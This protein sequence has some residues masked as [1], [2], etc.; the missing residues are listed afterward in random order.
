M[1]PVQGTRDFLQQTYPHLSLRS[2]SRIVA[3]STFSLNFTALFLESCTPQSAEE[4]FLFD[5]A[6]KQNF[7]RKET[8][9]VLAEKYAI[10]ELLIYPQDK[11]F[12]IGYQDDLLASEEE[13]RWSPPPPVPPPVVLQRSSLSPVFLDWRTKKIPVRFTLEPELFSLEELQG[14]LKTLL[15]SSE[16]SKQKEALNQMMLTSLDPSCKVEILMRLL[17]EELQH[18]VLTTLLKH[19]STLGLRKEI[20]DFFT[21]LLREQSLSSRLEM[22]KRLG[23]LS[24]LS[25]RE[26]DQKVLFLLWRSIL[27]EEQPLPLLQN[28]L[29]IWTSSA[30]LFYKDFLQ[31]LPL[32]LN[33]LLKALSFPLHSE[34][35]IERELGRKQREESSLSLS[36]SA[37]LRQARLFFLALGA[38]EPEEFFHQILATYDHTAD[39]MLRAFL[40]DILA[41]LVPIETPPSKASEK[42]A[43][44]LVLEMIKKSPFEKKVSSL[45]FDPYFNL[46]FSALKLLKT[47]GILPL[48]KQISRLDSEK[49]S[50]FLRLL[51][52]LLAGQTLLKSQEIEMLHAFI[53]GYRECSL[54]QKQLILDSPVLESEH[55]ELLALFVLKLVYK[56]ETIPESYRKQTL[57]PAFRRIGGAAFSPLLQELN[58]TQRPV[59]REQLIFLLG[60]V[61]LS[62]SLKSSHYETFFQVFVELKKQFEDSSALRGALGLA[63]GKLSSTPFLAREQVLEIF[64]V[65]FQELKQASTLFESQTGYAFL[66]GLGFLARA[67]HLEKTEVLKLCQFFFNLLFR[68]LP[69]DLV[70]EES[71]QE[72]KRYVFT[73]ATQVYTELL[74]KALFGL[75]Q[76][77]L[78]PDLPPEIRASLLVRCIRCFQDLIA[79]RRIWAPSHTLQLAKILADLGSTSYTP[80]FYKHEIIKTL[81]ARE[82]QVQIRHYLIELLV[83]NPS[84]EFDSYLQALLTTTL[85]EFLETPQEEL[86][87]E[88]Q[89]R[90]VY[91]LLSLLK[92]DREGITLKNSLESILEAFQKGIRNRIPGLY[93]HLKRFS[94]SEEVS[95]QLKT[96]LYKLLEGSSLF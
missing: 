89:T 80:V 16:A 19:L 42:I 81:F 64:H 21:F 56:L 22:V 11:G 43:D 45:E 20:T 35:E 40:L 9:E 76:I 23:Q 30:S 53:E 96:S 37:F 5:P 77:L 95:P 87:H 63:L 2:A 50:L 91:Q 66:E 82:D 55:D 13:K 46:L 58:K 27:Q 59:L 3:L 32:I 92:R 51:N 75:G 70:Q 38:V 28:L 60:E 12:L 8:L 18:D 79:Y 86:S 85:Q 25:L 41:T 74:P 44:L 61:A 47:Q 90:L 84:S 1:R 15:T 26:A 36:F 34:Q 24:S 6:L 88:D 73:D 62:R 49:R 69:K 4:Q 71:H 7:N 52:E 14:I 33:A 68:P 78:R 93:D 72:G 54:A 10:P 48:L 17:E 31:I 83:A 67:P 29:E 39:L 65:F 57:V 94:R